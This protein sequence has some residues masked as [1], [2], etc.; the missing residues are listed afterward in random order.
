MDAP[1]V[2]IAGSLH[3][4][5]FLHMLGTVLR[6]RHVRASRGENTAAAIYTKHQPLHQSLT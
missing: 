6:A 2:E 4:I 3:G 5:G 1:V